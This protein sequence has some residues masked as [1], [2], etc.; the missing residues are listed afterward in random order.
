VE[1]MEGEDYGARGLDDSLS[2]V[3]A[4]GMGNADCKL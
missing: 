2:S 3:G 1:S 4:Y